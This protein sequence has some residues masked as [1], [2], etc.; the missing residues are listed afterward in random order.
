MPGSTAFDL[1]TVQLSDFSKSHLSII[2]E[3]V[4]MNPNASL[5]SIAE[6]ANELA[7]LATCPSRITVEILL[8]L[9]YTESLIK[10]STEA[11]SNESASG[12]LTPTTIRRQL[13]GR[14]N[15]MQ[16]RMEGLLEG[17]TITSNNLK[18]FQILSQIDEKLLVQLLDLMSE[19]AAPLMPMAI[20]VMCMRQQG[21]SEDDIRF[22]ED[23]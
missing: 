2:K 13:E 21:E 1:K 20:I 23:I 17:D 5:A 22:V 10:I 8:A 6:Q 18:V 4:E 19:D 15:K 7:V 9:G 12:R 14:H 16:S 3:L 11:D